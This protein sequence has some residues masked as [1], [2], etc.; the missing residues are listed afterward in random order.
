MTQPTRET[1][2]LNFITD[3]G[4][5]LASTSWARRVGAAADVLLGAGARTGAGAGA[6][7]GTGT[8]LVT[9]VAVRSAGGGLTA[10]LSLADPA[11]FFDLNLGLV[12]AA[13]GAATLAAI[14]GEGACGAW[15]GSG[16]T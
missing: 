13:N 9:A 7:T 15:A 4:S 16:G 2:K 5:I 3:Q 12:R 10:G 1:M 6:G 8:G 11:G 14:P